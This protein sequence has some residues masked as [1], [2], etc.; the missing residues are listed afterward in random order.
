MALTEQTVQCPYC[1]ETIEILIDPQDVG[2]QYVED[3]QVCC[4][5]INFHIYERVSDG[6]EG[7]VQAHVGRD[8]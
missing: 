5:P 4:Q 3:C 1:W 2:Q 8:D 6:I 7:S